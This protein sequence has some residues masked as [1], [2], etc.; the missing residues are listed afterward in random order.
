MSVPAGIGQSS[1]YFS[2][3]FAVIRRAASQLVRP[4]SHWRRAD[5]AKRLTRRVLL[6]TAIVAAV[7]IALMYGLDASEIGLMPPRGTTSLW[8]VRILTDFGK[9]AYV[10][11]SLAAML[12]IVALAAP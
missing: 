11:C 5:A 8:P 7:I 4:P 10:L 2:Q 12:V 9:D 3:A 1:N 6:L